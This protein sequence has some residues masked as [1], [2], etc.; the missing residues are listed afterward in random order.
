MKG[1]QG[2]SSPRRKAEIAVK[3]GAGLGSS[4]DQ[5]LVPKQEDP[6]EGIGFKIFVSNFGSKF[7]FFFCY[8]VLMP[9]RPNT[10]ELITVRYGQRTTRSVVRT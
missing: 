6:D 4:P 1:V 2:L 9:F 7:W 5:I 10:R 3:P 8:H